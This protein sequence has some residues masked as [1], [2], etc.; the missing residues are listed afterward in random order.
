MTRQPYA[1]TRL[2]PALLAECSQAHGMDVPHVKC[3]QIERNG[4]QWAFLLC[5]ASLVLALKA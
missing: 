5:L 3:P 2:S 4:L 1:R